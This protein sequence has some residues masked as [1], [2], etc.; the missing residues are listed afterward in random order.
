MPKDVPLRV[1]VRLWLATGPAAGERRERLSDAL[2]WPQARL[3]F[4]HELPLEG[5]G[6]GS[7]AFF[8]PGEAT[9]IACAARLYFDPERPQQG[10]TAELLALEVAQ[11]AALEAFVADGDPA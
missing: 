9:P 2:R 1:T 3:H 5:A 10:S 6:E 11:Q 8:L 7:V 4:P